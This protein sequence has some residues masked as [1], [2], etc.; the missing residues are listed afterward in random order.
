MT[1]EALVQADGYVLRAPIWRGDKSDPRT[2]IGD[3]VYACNF[4]RAS[5]PHPL[6]EAGRF[7]APGNVGLSQMVK[8]TR[9]QAD[10]YARAVQRASI[11]EAQ[12]RRVAVT[13]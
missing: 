3:D 9:A 12:T 10:A 6:E 13:A 5:R 8:S 11:A 2:L 7:H 4:G 1:T